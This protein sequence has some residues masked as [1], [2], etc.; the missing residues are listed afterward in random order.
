MVEFKE[1]KIA[2][3]TS[4]AVV[5][6]GGGLSATIRCFDDRG[7]P[8]HLHMSRSALEHL[9]LQA[10]RALENTPKPARGAS[11]D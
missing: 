4:T 7:S 11:S 8:L 1:M 3:I 2:N 5:V 10:K 6:D 9:L